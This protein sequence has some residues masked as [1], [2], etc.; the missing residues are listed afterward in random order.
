MKLRFSLKY[1]IFFG[2]LIIIA[3]SAS[4]VLINY[5]SLN[6]INNLSSKVIPISDETIVLVNQL[7]KLVILES[8]IEEYVLINSEEYKDK[9]FSEIDVIIKKSE[10]LDASDKAKSDKLKEGLV[11]LD[12]N[13]KDL[14]SLIGGKGTSDDV[15]QQT[16]EVYESIKYVKNI[17]EDILEEKNR[18]L[19]D[20]IASQQV[21][22]SRIFNF[23]IIIE[24]L[25]IFFGVFVS[26]LIS[27]LILSELFKLQK[28][29]EEISAGKLESEVTVSSNDEIG[30]LA[31]SFDKMRLGLKDRNDLLDSLLKTF[32][33]KFGNI[34]TILVRK[35]VSELINKNPR[36]EKILPSYLRKSV[37]RDREARK[38]N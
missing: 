20:N 4:F 23:L 5:S 19:N 32:K 16:L 34:A 22:V 15:N 25:I 37:K 12:Y 28:L 14:T 7:D 31:K 8:S 13:V 1:K 26:F 9:V 18:D 3:L 30:E 38:V 10:R 27:K 6:E 11:S 17:F 35:D 33:G 36:I 2:F 21:I 24:F 29:T